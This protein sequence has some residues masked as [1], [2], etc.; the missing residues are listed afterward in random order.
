MIVLAKVPIRM[1]Y[2]L[3][4]RQEES[5]GGMQERKREM[6]EKVLSSRMKTEKSKAD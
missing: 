6:S 4:E 1:L 3:R 2:M 5:L